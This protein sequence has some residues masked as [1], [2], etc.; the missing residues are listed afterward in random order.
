M[1]SSV[2]PRLEKAA[3]RT[4]LEALPENFYEGIDQEEDLPLDGFGNRLPYRDMQPGSIIP[5]AGE[6]L[7]AVGEQGQPHIWAF[8]ITHFGS[9]REAASDLATETDLA[10]IGWEPTQNAGPINTFYFTTYDEF[11]KSGDRIGWLATRFYE[12]T[13]GS[14]VDFTL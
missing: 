14:Q 8:Q 3:I 2:D 13:L 1:V 7:L 12:T 6:R 10:L 4:R 9:T 11:S 5:A